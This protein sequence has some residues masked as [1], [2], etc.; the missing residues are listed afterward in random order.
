MF[1]A[2]G[3][4]C[5]D[6]GRPADSIQIIPEGVDQ[7]R[8]SYEVGLQVSFRCIRSGYELNDVTPLTCNGNGDGNSP[9]WSADLPVC[10]GE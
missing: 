7:S 4:T 8:L 1:S 9:T 10:V 5:N 6:P 3:P 2:S